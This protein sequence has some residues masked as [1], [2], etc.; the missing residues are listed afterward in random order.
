VNTT[1]WITNSIIANRSTSLVFDE[2]V[3]AI[4]FLL[5]FFIVHIHLTLSLQDEIL[6]T[7]EAPGGYVV[8]NRARRQNAIDLHTVRLLDAKIKVHPTSLSH[9]SNKCLYLPSYYQY[10]VCFYQLLDHA[11][12]IRF[13][14][15]RGS[16]PNLCGGADFK[17]TFLFGFIGCVFQFAIIH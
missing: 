10:S 6:V 9:S 7:D 17:S 12:N 5:H 4:V 3:F 11:K 8:L 16:G 13:I 15:L 14:M 2:Y 1:S